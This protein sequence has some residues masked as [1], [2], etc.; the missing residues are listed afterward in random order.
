M[1]EADFVT[2]SYENLRSE[3]LGICDQRATNYILRQNDTK[4]VQRKLFGTKKQEA[5][6]KRREMHNE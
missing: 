4:I 1:K 6:R 2:L 3:I 5:T